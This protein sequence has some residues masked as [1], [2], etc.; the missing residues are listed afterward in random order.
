MRVIK[1]NGNTSKRA[2]GVIL[3]SLQDITSEK[4][5]CL[6]FC[7]S[8]SEAENIVYRISVNQPN[9]KTEIVKLEI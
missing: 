8:L 7:D 9:L 6:Q 1:H 2:Y 3:Y 5:D 4:V